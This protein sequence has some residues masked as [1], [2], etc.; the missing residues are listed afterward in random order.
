MKSILPIVRNRISGITL[1]AWFAVMLALG[2]GL[3]AKHMV[4]LPAPAKDEKLAASLEA[5]RG[6]ENRGRWLA[7]HALY[8]DCRCSQRV[9]D[10]LVTTARPPDWSEIVLWVGN[11]PPSAALEKRFD[12]RR[13][14]TADLG[15]YGIEAAP[16]LVALD[17]AGHV[18]Y[19][20]GYTDRKQGPVIDDLRILE[21]A[22]RPDIVA[23]LP[24]F[25]CAVSDRLRRQLEAFTT[26]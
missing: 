7:V 2:A 1:V 26:L 25:G 16:I 18:R 9:V 5:L 17:P 22:R 20:G 11:Q 6:P 24:V 8:A 3:L 15:R 21:A 14:G 10:H 19:S 4:A 12:V 13:I 23:S